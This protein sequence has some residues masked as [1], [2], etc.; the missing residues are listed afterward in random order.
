MK[1]AI[2][3]LGVLFFLSILIPAN[4]Q[5]IRQLPIKGQSSTELAIS[6]PANNA[7]VASPLTITGTAPKNSKILVNIKAIFTNGSQDLGTFS[8]SANSR[9]KWQSKP[10]TLWAPKGAKNLRYEITASDAVVVK[11]QKRRVGRQGAN[12]QK[13]TVTPVK[14]VLLL[15]EVEMTEKKIKALNPELTPVSQ[16]VIFGGID[17]NT[18]ET[19]I[20]TPASNK[21]NV[22]ITS[23]SRNTKVDFPL[24]IEGK[25][26]KNS[27]IEVVIAQIF[28]QYGQSVTK[29]TKTEAISDGSGNWKTGKLYSIQAN[30][31]DG[32]VKLEISAVMRENGRKTSNTATIT[33]SSD[34]KEKLW[35]KIT[36]PESNLYQGAKVTSPITVRGRAM[37][38]NTLEI[39]VQT[40]QGYASNYHNSGRI[41]KDWTSVSV[42]SNGHWSAQLNTGKPKTTNGRAPQQE[43]YLTILVRDKSKKSE[44]KTLQLR[45]Q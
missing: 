15:S 1:N 24:M 16:R 2:L 41:I 7:S 12:V 18:G 25:A 6:S 35:L 20:N 36:S 5:K 8:T 30:V 9:G 27:T 3:Y 14:T 4:A 32:N 39:R 11:D 28:S 22:S 42:D 29:T 37:K 38:N 23:P 21:V 13:V 19:I 26:K 17:R 10:I 34:P 33:V 44:I 40:G 45:R 31:A 43:Y